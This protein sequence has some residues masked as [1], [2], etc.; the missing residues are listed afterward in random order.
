S[1]DDE[2]LPNKVYKIKNTSSEIFNGLENTSNEVVTTF[3]AYN[4]PIQSVIKY[5]LGTT[6]QK[7]E[8]TDIQYE[9][10]VSG[11]SY[12]VGRPIQK[13]TETVYGSSTM[14]T[15]EIYSYNSSHLL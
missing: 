13:N 3:D 9:N 7:T 5:K 10:L 2:L 8:T 15:E 11:G 4:N 1:Y 14:T 6:V 12:I